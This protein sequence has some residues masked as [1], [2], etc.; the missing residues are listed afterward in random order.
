MHYA[1]GDWALTYAFYKNVGLGAF[2]ARMSLV[3]QHWFNQRATSDGVTLI[4]GDAAQ[5]TTSALI[6][7]GLFINEAT[8]PQSK[9]SIYSARSVYGD[10]FTSGAS[11]NVRIDPPA[12]IGAAQDSPGYLPP[13]TA[14]YTE[15]YYDSIFNLWFDPRGPSRWAVEI[16]VG[17]IVLG[18]N[19]GNAALFS[20]ALDLPL[21]GRPLPYSIDEQCP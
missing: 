18:G 7:G 11:D 13:V 12:Q 14:T 8:A 20:R 6:A 5:F 16:R 19:K 15:G 10:D 2:T 1:Y 21:P 3:Y 9:I 17:G 4:L